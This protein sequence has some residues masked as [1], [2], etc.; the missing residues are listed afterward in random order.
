MSNERTTFLGDEST[1]HLTPVTYFKMADKSFFMA[2]DGLCSLLNH[3][4]S[5]GAKSCVK[6]MILQQLQQLSP[7]N[8]S[9]QRRTAK[10]YC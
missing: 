4:V 7:A 1:C 8:V 2:Q 3:I 6:T 5:G 9:H 10:F